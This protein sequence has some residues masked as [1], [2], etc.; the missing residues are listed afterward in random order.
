MYAIV[1][2]LDTNI[3]GNVYP[4]NHYNQAYSDIRRFLEPKGF[5]WQQGSTYFGNENQTAVSCTAAVIELTRQFP[6]LKQ[7]I[8]DI[9][10]L[11]IEENNDLGPIID[12]A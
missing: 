10:M 5:E 4:G 7:A 12:L 6:W 11:R 8:R 1:F 3:L 2:D 9:R